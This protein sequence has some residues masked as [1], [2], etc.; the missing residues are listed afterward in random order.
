MP[1]NIIAAAF[2]EGLS[3]IPGGW[4]AVKIIPALAL[5]YLL[6][7]YFNGAVNLSERNMHSKVVM[8][9]GGTAGIGA[10][11]V[12]GLATRG[13]QIV[14][15]VQQPLTDPFFVDY[16]EDLRTETGNELITAEHVDL[17][18]LHSIRLFA[19]KWVDNAPPR[20]LDMIILCAN[21][22]TPPGGKATMTEDGLESTWGLNYIANFHLLSILSPALRAQPP[23]RDVRIIFGTCSA[24]M[25]GKLPEFD[26][27]PKKG[28]KA[29]ATDPVATS[30]YATSK[31]ALMTFADAF[32]KHL[33]NYARPD[34]KPMNARVIMVDPGW[35]RTPGMR[36][37]L[38]FGSLWGLALYIFMWPLWWLVL[39]S[40]DQG[41][42]TFLYAA[43]EAQWGRGEGSY[44]LKECRRVTWTRKE[45][46]DEVLQKQLWESS[47][48]TIEVLEKESAKR[49]AVEKK[50]KEKVEKAEAKSTAKEANGDAKQRKA[51]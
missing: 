13:A 16:I 12:K 44:F 7:W 25:G 14:L 47:S 6:K 51:K 1:V 28:A 34:K 11:V 9:T 48:K 46:E 41:A 17:T 45:I 4:T 31:L 24:Y 21:T 5:L 22:M 40:G 15:L 10:E 36:R 30:V 8:V 35:T 3:S 33:S 42:Q 26:A 50:E 19:T 43:M 27:K 39:K 49:R 32:Q 20:R 29:E 18:S 37:F 23:D 38:T 2:S